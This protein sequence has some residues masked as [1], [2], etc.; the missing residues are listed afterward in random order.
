MA[1]HDGAISI[2]TRPSH[3]RDRQK[4]LRHLRTVTGPALERWHIEYN[5]VAAALE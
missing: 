4:V 2:C 5:N 3:S 1:P